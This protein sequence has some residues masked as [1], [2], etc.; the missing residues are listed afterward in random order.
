LGRLSRGAATPTR[1]VLLLNGEINPIEYF[2]MTIVP[3]LHYAN[4]FGTADM[5]TAKFWVEVVMAFKRSVD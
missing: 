1:L 3:N 4:V 2:A 5:S